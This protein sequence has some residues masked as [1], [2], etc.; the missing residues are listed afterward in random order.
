MASCFWVAVDGLAR[1]ERINRLLRLA[2]GYKQLPQALSS[3]FNFLLLS[4]SIHAVR[5]LQNS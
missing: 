5:R 1:I 4:R 2:S 3:N